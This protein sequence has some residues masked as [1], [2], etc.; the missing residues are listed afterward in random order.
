MPWKRAKQARRGCA[1]RICPWG[2]PPVHSAALT[3]EALPLSSQPAPWLRPSGKKSRHQGGPPGAYLNPAN[4]LTR[5]PEVV[6]VFKNRQRNPPNVTE[7]GE[8]D[9]T[10]WVLDRNYFCVWR[11]RTGDASG[12]PGFRPRGCSRATEI[13]E[14]TGRTNQR[15]VWRSS[16][17]AAEGREPCCRIIRDG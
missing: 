15:C 2:N 6:F 10:D 1:R 4:R 3:S 17:N 5:G 13:S 8:T 7:G 16:E 12:P 11:L 9:R 14:S